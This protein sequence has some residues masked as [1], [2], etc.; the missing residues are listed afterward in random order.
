MIQIKWRAL[1]GHIVIGTVRLVLISNKEKMKNP[2]PALMVLVVMGYS[3]TFAQVNVSKPD[4]N[5]AA[6]YFVRTSNMGFAINFSYFD[7]LR[8]IGRFAGAGYIRY[9]CNPGKHLFWARSENRDFVEAELE[10]GKVYFIQANVVTGALKAQVDLVPVNPKEDAKIMKRINKLMKNQNAI[11][12][13][14]VELARDSEDLEKVVERSM[15]TYAE[16]QEKGKPHDVLTADM[17]AEK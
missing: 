5:N 9:E 2:I 14:D 16:E 11:V 1:A 17:D 8:L 3:S 10:A 15:K 13:S 12:F 4:A 6:V 7:S